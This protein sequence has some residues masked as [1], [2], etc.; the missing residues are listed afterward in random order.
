MGHLQHHVRQRLFDDLLE[1]RIACGLP[2]MEVERD[3]LCVVVEHLLEVRD[4]P[5]RVD[6]VTS[7]A[8]ADLVIDA[9]AGHLLQGCGDHV[10]R[11]LVAG[12]LPV[13]Q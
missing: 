11:I 1:Q 12:A 2:C 13:T 5:E 3:E 9:A 10:Q 8:A 4:E 6:R 7:E